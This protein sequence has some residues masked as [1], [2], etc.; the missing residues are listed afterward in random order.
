[1]LER[2]LNIPNLKFSLLLQEKEER[3]NQKWKTI[4]HVKNLF[5]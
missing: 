3:K 1:M 2:G 5:N 4:G